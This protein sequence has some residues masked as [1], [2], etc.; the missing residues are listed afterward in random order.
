MRIGSRP[1]LAALAMATAVLAASCS[2]SPTAP[3]PVATVRRSVAVLV[4]DSLGA[5]AVG[6]PVTWISQ[7]DSAGTAILLGGATGSD[8]V[9]EAVLA[10]GG[11]IVAT[12]AGSPFA[13]VAG[14][15]FIVAGSVRA[16]ADTQLVRLV[17]HTGSRLAGVV[18][19][20]GMPDHR[21]TVVFGTFVGLAETDSTGAWA[22]DGVPLGRW[23]VT[24][25][26]PAFQEGIVTVAVTTPGSNVTAPSMTLRSEP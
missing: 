23:L 22:M 24:A 26:H 13:L 18:T 25:Y 9:A 11:W 12:G 16:P 4:A 6:V 2:R 19:L 15:S 1:L 21:G 5:P 7:F 14:A 17:L 3:R 10:E 20:A 8:G